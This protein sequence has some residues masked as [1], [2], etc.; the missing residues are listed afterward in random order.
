MLNKNSRQYG[1]TLVEMAIVITIMAFMAVGGAM[2]LSSQYELKRMSDTEQTLRAAKEALIGFAQVHGRLPCPA[3][4]T[5]AGQEAVGVAGACLTDV[6]VNGYY[7]FLPATTLGLARGGAAVC[8]GSGYLADAW[9]ACVRYAVSRAGSNAA[10]KVNG[11]RDHPMTTYSPNLRIC[12][13]NSCSDVLS[14]NLVV[15]LYSTGRT[16]LASPV[17]GN[18]QLEN[19]DND[20]DF[21]VRELSDA[22]HSR[23]E[24]D[25]IVEWVP[26]TTLIPRMVQAG[27]LP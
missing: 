14:N 5:S 10:T 26:V 2:V 21:V 22:Q 18:D 7:G 4:G 20:R 3:T 19:L 9:A 23:G 8:G 6:D 24:F 1:F 15:V 11:I 27:R 13:Q 12:R 25:D 16:G 17:S